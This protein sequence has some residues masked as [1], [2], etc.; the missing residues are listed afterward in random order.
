MNTFTTTHKFLAVTV[1]AGAL[2]VGAGLATA[3]A[4][5]DVK[6]YPGTM[7]ESYKVTKAPGQKKKRSLTKRGSVLSRSSSAGAPV[8]YSID[9]SIANRN[10]DVVSTVRCPIIRDT[11]TNKDGLKS[12]RISYV[13]RHDARNPLCFVFSRSLKDNKV[14]HRIYG[15]SKRNKGYGEI[16]IKGLSKSHDSLLYSLYCAIPP[17]LRGQPP[18]KLLNYEVEEGDKD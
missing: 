8:S 7:C 2:L 3:Q 18:S 14:S 9:G 1:A 10:E 11:T 6:I 16:V 17:Q 4:E 13:D 12:V 5:T 15:K